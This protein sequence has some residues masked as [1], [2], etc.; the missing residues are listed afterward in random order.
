M[1]TA[2][3]SPALPNPTR[4]VALRSAPSALAL[5]PRLT[6]RRCS[7]DVSPRPQVYASWQGWQRWQ[8]LLG[9]RAY[10]LVY[11]GVDTSVP[12]ARYTVDYV[13]NSV[14][15]LVRASREFV[16][17]AECP[18]GEVACAGPLGTCSGAARR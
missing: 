13:M 5:T 1:E 8:N 2:R 7:G 15:R 9:W 3:W 10:G 14:G 4:S 12:G 16:V 6:Q 17:Q 11:C 18:P